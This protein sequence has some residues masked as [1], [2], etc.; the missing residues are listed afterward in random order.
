MPQ[1]HWFLC[2][3]RDGRGPA[4]MP[5][6]DTFTMKDGVSGREAAII[7]AAG[8]DEN[9][10]AWR[11]VHSMIGPRILVH[12]F[13]AGGGLAGARVPAS[14]A[15]Q[16]S[17]MLAALLADLAATGHHELVTT[18]DS[19]FPLR[20]PSGVQVVTLPPSGAARLDDLIASVDGVWL[21]APE[22]GRCL[23]RLAARVERQGRALLGSGAAAIR[24]AS[25]KAALP[26]L[27]ARHSVA[28][29]KTRVVGPG[30]DWRAAARALGYPLVVKPARGAGCRGV[31]LA[32]DERELSTALTPG[33]DGGDGRRGTEGG[34]LLLQRYVP[35]V[36][37]SVTLVADGRRA[38]VL[39]VNAQW[40]RPGPR[41]F[42]YR[43]GTTPLDHP[44]A[45]QA[46]DAAA[47]AVEACPGLRGLVG[48][49]LVLTPST[50]IVIEINPRLTMAYIGLRASLDENVAA[51]ALRACAG[52]LP[53][54]GRARRVVS[55]TAAGRIVT[56][57]AR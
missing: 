39:A 42:S 28:H 37:A 7:R 49:D 24:R 11:I 3:C 12:E 50:A 23:E 22:T 47:R 54:A 19:R 14:L 30:S 26:V 21:V 43:G 55:F 29:P 44:L 34:R 46:A 32:R 51:L 16:G 9:A 15:R 57:T 10:R 27:L 53:A 17:A 18:A 31:R 38:A 2:V 13:V 33:L 35:G 1:S 4:L 8:R 5:V 40:V 56:A 36:A 20:V 6:T 41:A 45:C 25:D 52:V 48:V